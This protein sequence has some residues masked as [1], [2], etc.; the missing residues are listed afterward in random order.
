MFSFSNAK[1]SSIKEGRVEGDI[2]NFLRRCEEHPVYTFSC[3]MLLILLF[4]VIGYYSW[5]LLWNVCAFV[6]MLP[7]LSVFALILN[8]FFVE[9]VHRLDNTPK[10]YKI[11]PIVAFVG[12]YVLMAQFTTNQYLINGVSVEL[13]VGVLKVVSK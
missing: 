11:M 2:Q 7:I 13:L 1:P 10:M 8:I 3:L 5:D 9:F 4:W 6:T 12:C